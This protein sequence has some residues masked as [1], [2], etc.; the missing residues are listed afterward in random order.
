[1][2]FRHMAITGERKIKMATRSDS[3]QTPVILN[4]MRTRYDRRTA[5]VMQIPETPEKKGST[6]A[7]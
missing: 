4:A 1:M 2:K 7:R 6:D 3:V 5:K